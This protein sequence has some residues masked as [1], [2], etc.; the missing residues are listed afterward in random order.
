L[1][2]T[3]DP[4]IDFID[5]ILFSPSYGAIITGRLTDDESLGP[6]QRL[7]RAQDQW[8]YLRVKN[9]I[10]KK[11]QSDVTEIIPLVDYLFRY[12]RGAFWTGRYAYKYFLAPFDRFSRWVLDYF[13]RTRVLYH[14]LHESGLSNFYIIQ[15]L[16]LP[17]DKAVEFLDFVDN[18]LEIYPLWICPVMPDR[19]GVMNCYYKEGDTVMINIGVWGPGPRKRDKFIA[20]NKK[21][22]KVVRDLGGVKW[23]YAQTYY[24]YDEFWNIYDK[25][26]YDALRSK[27]GASGLPTVYDKVRSHWEA[28][29]TAR[30]KASL[31]GRLK[32]DAKEIWPLRG[33]YGIARTILGKNYL[34]HDKKGK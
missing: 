23:L 15:D 17:K 20:L 28:E 34:L 30:A 19:T 4:T 33:Y 27:Y 18:E 24:S 26:G 8:F 32:T 29:Q 3:D 31:L 25:E 22:E 9:G 14:A 10:S 11:K 12:D 1:E 21:I 2:A 7:S 16:A 5:G 6:P 13:M